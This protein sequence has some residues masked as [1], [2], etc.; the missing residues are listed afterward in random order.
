[1]YTEFYNLAEKPFDLTHSSRFLYLGE[2]HKEALA[3]LTY[4]IMERKGF[5]LLTGEVGTGKTTIVHALKAGLDKS[6]QCILLANPLL[7]SKEFMNYLTLSAF[8][9]RIAFKSKAEF[10]VAFEA[11]LTRCSEHQRSFLLLIDEAH[12]LS[13]DLLEEIR[14]LSNMETADEKLINIFLIGQ[15]ELNKKLNDPRCRAL[16]QR[17]SIRYN[18][19]PLSF[20]ETEEYITRRFKIAGAQKPDDIFPGKVRK[21]I[22]EYTRGF[23]RMIN[24]LSDNLLLLGYSRGQ[25]KLTPAMVRECFEDLQLVDP[26]PGPDRTPAPERKTANTKVEADT[27]PRHNGFR[28]WALVGLMAVLIFVT[29]FYYG[30]VIR[31]RFIELI[32]MGSK[33]LSLSPVREENKSEVQTTIKP[34]ASGKEEKKKFEIPKAMPQAAEEAQKKTEESA[35]SVVEHPG[36]PETPESYA[37]TDDNPPVPPLWKPH[38]MSPSAVRPTTIS[39]KVL[40]SE[41]V[42]GN[43]RDFGETIIVRD[44]DTLDKLSKRIYGRSDEKIWETIQKSNPDIRDVDFIRPG[45]KL[46]FP[47]IDEQGQPVQQT[48]QTPEG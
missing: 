10:L 14:L 1:V 42:L 47:A 19:R 35:P 22:Y 24:V 11:F 32:S 34:Q 39:P 48:G 12:K 15:P 43:K 16:L 5:V 38:G 17:I 46:V 26:T 25:R 31:T 44:G 33:H 2:V 37:F 40:G 27:P 36:P 18:I 41:G 30:E 8:K 6:V 29:A 20:K 45:Q 3:I 4:G 7:S 9:N 28:K 13:F 21:A 23:P